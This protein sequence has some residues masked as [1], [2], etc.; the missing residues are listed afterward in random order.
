MHYP[1]FLKKLPAT[2]SL[3]Q[4][5]REAA[6]FSRKEGLLLVVLLSIP[7]II[8]QL[9]SV[10]MH[11]IDMAM[12]GHLG[13]DEAAA[14]GLVSTTIWMF[15]GI[16]SAGITGFHVL[17]GQR[18]GAR[19]EKAVKSL[20]RQSLVVTFLW[21]M[22]LAIVGVLIAKE[23]PHWLGAT[24]KVA[25]LATEYFQ[26]VV[27]SWSLVLVNFLETGMLRVSGN[28]KAPS[29]LGIS[30]CVLDVFFNALFIFPARTATLFGFDV[31][32]PGFGWGVAG[33][34][35]ATVLATALVLLASLWMACVKSEHLA[36]FKREGSFVPQLL[37]LKN[38]LRIG[39]PV[40]IQRIV[41]N[42]A[43][44]ISTM[45]VA[46]LG[47]VALVAHS[48]A[49]TVESLCYMPGFGIR[50]AATTLCSQTIGAGHIKRAR[51]VGALTIFVGVLVM[52]FM[53]LLMFFGAE[54]MM[55]TMTPDAEAVKLGA[56]ILRIEAFAEPMYAA[57]IVAYGCF[58]GA[59]D[60]LIP[61]LMNLLSMWI[62]RLP[63]AFWLAQSMGLVGVW[64]AM[65]LELFFRGAIFLV[66][67][68]RGSWLTRAGRSR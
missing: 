56:T 42:G 9:A 2:E 4:R 39:L 3:M 28:M 21:G 25:S 35:W 11:Y 43:Q 6:S 24:G 1:V 40:S 8:A 41:M 5:L 30:M 19:D 14:V 31:Y 27:A 15:W 18:I 65:C 34:A 23:L 26:I 36:I 12:L 48:F 60:T 63:L 16:G 51:E 37:D 53:G 61:S 45:I 62:V 64:I 33:A 22:L 67:F 49:L 50:E 29:I 17:V 13:S 57:S 68:Y 59:A 7:A 54:A 46:P 66:R 55:R 38:S 44:I 10:L 47:T 58:L 32:L 20:M 52:S